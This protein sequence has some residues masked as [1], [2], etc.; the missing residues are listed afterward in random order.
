MLLLGITNL[1]KAWLSDIVRML[2]K[3]RQ[4]IK[5][6]EKAKEEGR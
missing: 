1:L 3:E 6:K 5:R 2:G 4:Q